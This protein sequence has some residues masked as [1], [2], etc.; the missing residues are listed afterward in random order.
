LFLRHVQQLY[1]FSKIQLSTASMLH[2]MHI[3]CP[4]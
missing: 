1:H 4:V 2:Y 3:A